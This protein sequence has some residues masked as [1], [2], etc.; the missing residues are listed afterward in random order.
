[1]MYHLYDLVRAQRG[2]Y[3]TKLNQIR[4]FMHQATAGEHVDAETK[5]RYYPRCRPRTISVWFP[6]FHGVIYSGLMVDAL[7]E[8]ILTGL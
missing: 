5:L 7:Q 3:N 4:A 2:A 8:T 6:G 1:M